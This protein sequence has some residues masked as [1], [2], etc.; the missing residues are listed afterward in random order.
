MLTN[1]GFTVFRCQFKDVV[2]SANEVVSSG[3]RKCEDCMEDLKKGKKKGNVR[4][5]RLHVCR[6]FWPNVGISPSSAFPAE[7]A[8][9]NR[10]PAFEPDCPL[11][12][13]SFFMFP[14]FNLCVQTSMP[15]WSRFRDKNVGISVDPELSLALRLNFHRNSTYFWSGRNDNRKFGNLMICGGTRQQCVSLVKRSA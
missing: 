1:T 3:R 10:Q 14:W 12:G 13:A 15:C 4:R 7:T 8:F 2:E 9:V 11:R 5:Q 6:W